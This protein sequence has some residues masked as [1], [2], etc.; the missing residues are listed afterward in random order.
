MSVRC[1]QQEVLS[2]LTEGVSKHQSVKKGGK[3]SMCFSKV[4]QADFYYY[5][6]TNLCM[7]IVYARVC[8]CVLW[9]R[10]VHGCYC[11]CRC[12]YVCSCV[13]CTLVGQEWIGVL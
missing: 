1:P 5:V 13:W 10:C 8:V 7:C 3:N 4:L 2:S 11:I 6:C 12:V 9:E